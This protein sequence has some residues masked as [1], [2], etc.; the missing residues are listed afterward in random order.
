MNDGSLCRFLK[1]NHAP[2]LR[3]TIRLHAAMLLIVICFL[4]CSR[5]SGPDTGETSLSKEVRN[6]ISLFRQLDLNASELNS[7]ADELEKQYEWGPSLAM[8]FV[9]AERGDADAQFEMGQMFDSGWLRHRYE[10]GVDVPSALYWYGKSAGQGNE[11]AQCNLGAV[12]FDGYGVKTDKKRG[13]EYY[14]RA[15]RTG[16]ARASY[17]LG[18]MYLRGDGFEKDL[19]RSG[20]ILTKLA[21]L[22]YGDAYDEIYSTIADN[23]EGY[24]V[25]KELRRM[26]IMDRGDLK[27]QEKAHERYISRHRH[28]RD[29]MDMMPWW[30]RIVFVLIV[31]RWIWMG[32]KSA[33]AGLK[34][35]NRVSWKSFRGMMYEEWS[36]FA[37]GF[38]R[39]PFINVLNLA[40]ISIVA[41][42]ILFDGIGGIR[43]ALFS[44]CVLTAAFTL[45]RLV[46]F[47]VDWGDLDDC[48]AYVMHFWLR[49]VDYMQNLDLRY[50]AEEQEWIDRRLPSKTWK[51]LE[52]MVVCGILAFWGSKLQ[53]LDDKGVG[54][55]WV[56]TTIYLVVMTV[57]TIGMGAHLERRRLKREGFSE[58]PGY[59]V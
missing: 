49:D 4:S 56:L 38:R 47:G 16:S 57:F 54:I 55:H 42:M 53:P 10:V 36:L 50:T 6:N 7:E 45:F 21:K 29:I 13:I 43:Y 40:Y 15:A 5:N 23:M 33:A 20:I 17:E 34:G 32:C 51:R 30:L 58:S 31:G 14:R 22:G 52:L 24:G 8:R 25:G 41:I 9:A 27:L 48:F 1:L 44:A 3:D 28:W 46:G 2:S 11:K 39:N 26:G 37:A 18:I 35:L 59:L 12:Y 19:L